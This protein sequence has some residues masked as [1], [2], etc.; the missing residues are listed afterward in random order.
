M[1][2]ILRHLLL[3][4]AILLPAACQSED[5]TV[6]QTAYFKSD[7]RDRVIAYHSQEKLT[8]AE[9]RDISDG[10][11]FT[12][13]RLGRIAFYSGGD[14]PSPA[15]AVTLARDLQAALIAIA[16]PPHDDWDWLFMS[17]PSGKA[18]MRAR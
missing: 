13:G 9:A 3:T 18:E 16:N 10:Q 12:A 8:E 1:P 15:D 5:A 11:T 4:V 2:H 6:N 17:H 14:N 7:E